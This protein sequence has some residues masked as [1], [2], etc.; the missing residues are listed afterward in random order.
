MDSPLLSRRGHP[1]YPPSDISSLCEARHFLSHWGQT[2]QPKPCPHNRFPPVEREQEWLVPFQCSKREMLDG[3]RGR[4]IRIHCSENSNLWNHHGNQYG[5]TPT[6][7]PK[8]T[9]NIKWLFDPAIPLLAIWPKES[10]SSCYRNSCTC[11][12]TIALFTTATLWKKARCPPVD[13]WIKKIW[14]IN[15]VEFLPSHKEE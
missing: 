7:P 5:G 4:G 1:G 9:L 10:K 8:K 2:R 14:H 11:M 15:K 6:V 13:E 12:F 3:C